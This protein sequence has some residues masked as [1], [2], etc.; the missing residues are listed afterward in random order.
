VSAPRGWLAGLVGLALAAPEA[1]RATGTFDADSALARARALVPF[2]AHA[3]A[4]PLWREFDARMR[5]ALKDSAAFAV[6]LSSMQAQ[7]GALD[8]VLTDSRNR[9]RSCTARSAGSPGFRSPWRSSSRST[10]RDA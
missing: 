9:A 10:T 5:A 2:V 4:A 8:S 3:E 7:M 6:T 1:S